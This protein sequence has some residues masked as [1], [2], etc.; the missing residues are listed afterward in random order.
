[1]SDTQRSHDSEVSDWMALVDRDMSAMLQVGKQLFGHEFTPIYPL[2][3]LAYGA[4]KRNL[5]TARAIVTMVHD[6][7][8]LGARALLRVHIDTSLRFS[9]AWLVAE[10]HDFAMEVMRGE[11]IDKQVDAKGKKLTDAYLVSVH[12]SEHSWLPKVYEALSGYVHFSGAHIYDSITAV[13]ELDGKFTI[14][15]STTDCKYPSSSW[16]EVLACCREATVLLASY[17]HG[18]IVTKGLSSEELDAVW[19]QSDRYRKRTG[20]G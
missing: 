9:A 17:L 10:P 4:L 11:R 15:L 6:W 12:A 14:D 3:L 19:K 7:N 5:S 16:V 8:M 13:G 1:M 18:Y 20:A 2:D